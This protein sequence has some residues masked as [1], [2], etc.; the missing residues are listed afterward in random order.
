MNMWYNMRA[1]G[2]AFV[3]TVLWIDYMDGLDLSIAC[4]HGG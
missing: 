4:A 3:C 2:G 1:L